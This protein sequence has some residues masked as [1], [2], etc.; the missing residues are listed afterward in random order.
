MKNKICDIHAHIVPAIDDGAIDLNM[1]IEMLRSAYKQGVR[2]IVCTSHSYCYIER[3][4]KNLEI[5]NAWAKREDIDIDLYSGCEVYANLYAIEDL[6]ACLDKKI[7]PTI[8]GTKYVLMEFNPSTSANEIVSYIAELHKYGY[9]T[10]LAHTERYPNLFE[11]YR[12]IPTLQQEGCLLQVNAYSFKNESKKQIRDFARKLL[13]EK[14]ITFIG[15][16]AHR[17]TH[18]PYAVQDGVC[19][20]YENCDAEYAK[21]ICYRNAERIL[22]IK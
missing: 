5:L 2:S 17:T 1:G 18:R 21:D 4:A 12:W 14:R 16:D 11:D 10:I 3:Y 7:F 15:S 19:D 22:N 13:S 20:I 6:V 8:N 9:K